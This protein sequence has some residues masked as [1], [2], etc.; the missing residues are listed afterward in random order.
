MWSL[1]CTWKEHKKDAT[2]QSG[3]SN[4]HFEVSRAIKERKLT[5]WIQATFT[6]WQTSCFELVNYDPKAVNITLGASV[7]LI[8]PLTQNFRGGPQQFCK[9]LMR[10]SHINLIAFRLI[11]LWS[12]RWFITKSIHQLKSYFIIWF[13][14]AEAL[15]NFEIMWGFKWLKKISQSE[16]KKIQSWISWRR[17]S[18]VRAS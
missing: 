18:A 1:Q 17:F 8:V 11:P 7:V 6:E 10:K 16:V 4:F 9:K 3:T 14:R 2:I 12:F 15:S 13:C 5:F